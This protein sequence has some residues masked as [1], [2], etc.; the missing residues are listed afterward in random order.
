VAR[1]VLL[2]V[3]IAAG[4]IGLVLGPVV[5]FSAKRR[6]Q[7]TRLGEAYFWVYIALVIG[8]FGLA[9]LNW[10]DDWFLVPVGIFSFAFALLGYLAAKRRPRA[11]LQLHVTGQGGSYIAM[12]TA[13]LVVNAGTDAVFAWIAP[14]LV[15]SPLIAYV[16]S[17]IALGRRPKGRADLGAAARIPGRRPSGGALRPRI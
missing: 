3:H 15:G 17:Q 5:A 16:N 13:L 12:T 7:H 11:W 14:T 10:S 2:S 4:T 9:A 1:D 6:G 8:A